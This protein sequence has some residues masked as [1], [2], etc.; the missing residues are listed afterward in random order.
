MS[1]PVAGGKPNSPP[2]VPSVVQ[3]YVDEKDVIGL[4]FQK[5]ESHEQKGQT[6]LHKEDDDLICGFGF[7]SVTSV[8]F[9][10]EF[11]SFPQNSQEKD[12]K[13]EAF[14]TAS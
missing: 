2:S 10:N 8:V 11:R 7:S 3:L 6:A 12:T 9:P 13:K 14:Q 1:P 4:R 5:R